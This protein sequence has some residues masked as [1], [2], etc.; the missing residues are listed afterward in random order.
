[1]EFGHDRAQE[2]GVLGLDAARDLF[3]EFG[4][5]FAIFRAQRETV[6]H[7]GIGGVGNV[8][9]FGHATPRPVDRMVQLV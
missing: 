4:T 3:D 2:L 1:M 7:R 5:N 9:S 6:E 8:H